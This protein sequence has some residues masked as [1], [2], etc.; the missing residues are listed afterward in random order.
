MDAKDVRMGG[1]YFAID[2][3]RYESVEI[4]ISGLP[5]YRNGPLLGVDI[6]TG[7]TLLIQPS[8]L[9]E[10]M[11]ELKTVGVERLLSSARTHRELADAKT[12]CASRIL[13]HP[14]Q[15]DEEEDEDDDTE[16]WPTH[17]HG[18][19]A[20]IGSIGCFWPG[21]DAGELKGPNE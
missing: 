6:E 20:T 3:D 2:Q 17:D 11:A 16:E 1:R 10:S 18:G 14:P 7:R 13:G 5:N 12:R 15:G 19:E 9:Y 21:D 8:D 4:I